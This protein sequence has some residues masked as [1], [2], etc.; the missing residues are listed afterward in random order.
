MPDQSRRQTHHQALYQFAAEHVGCHHHAT[1]GGH[2]YRWV[3]CTA[4]GGGKWAYYR[5]IASEGLDL[6]EFLFFAR[7]GRLARERIINR[8]AT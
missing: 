4:G 3:E 6:H 5:L 8:P 7:D 2:R 1:I